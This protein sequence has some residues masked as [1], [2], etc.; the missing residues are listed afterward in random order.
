MSRRVPALPEITGLRFLPE[1]TPASLVNM[2]QTGLLAESTMRLRVGSDITVAFE[3]G[4]KPDTIAGRVARCEVAV[5]ALDGQLRYHTAVEFNAALDFE[6]G[7][8]TAAPSATLVTVRN[9]W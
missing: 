9:R 1:R 4:F 2:S 8:D 7:D 6:D 3:G 5:M